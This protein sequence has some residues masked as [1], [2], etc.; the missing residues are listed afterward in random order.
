M[1][2]IRIHKETKD[3]L[4]A[5]MD[6]IKGDYLTQLLFIDSAVKTKLHM[7]RI[8]TPKDLI[9]AHL[10][11]LKSSKQR[12]LDKLSVDRAIMRHNKRIQRAKE[13]LTNLE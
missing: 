3:V 12:H 9:L 1:P 7:M 10:K 2:Q 4:D 8:K 11:R 6:A 5:N 13:Y